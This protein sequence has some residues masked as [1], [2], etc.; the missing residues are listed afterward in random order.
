MGVLDS[1]SPSDPGPEASPP[2]QLTLPERSGR[3]GGMSET[4]PVFPRSAYDAVGGL[5]YFARMLDKIRLHADGRLSAAYHPFL[6]EGFDGRMC[7]FLGVEYSQVRD[8]TLAGG[9][10]EEILEWCR[11]IGHPRTEEELLWWSKCAAKTGW[12]D[13]DTGAT[14][15]LS[16]NKAA[17]GLADRHDLVTFF[18]FYE[19]DEKRRP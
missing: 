14:Q 2:I 5:V 10:D 16:D 4:P 6:G 18:D 12:R 19:V 17:N 8:R 13:E 11:Q 7:R 1:A 3:V 15:R 9:S